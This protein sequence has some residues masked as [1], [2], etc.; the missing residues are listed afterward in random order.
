MRLAIISGGSKG[1]GASLCNQYLAAGFTVVEFSRS[2]P[3]DYSI[4]V[5]LADPVTTQQT[6]AT[7]LRALAGQKWDEI[8]VI[9]NAGVLDPIGPT[10]VKDP[11]AVLANINTNFA[12]AIVFISEVVGAFQGHAARKIIASVSSGAALKGYAGWSLYCA[13]KAGV[14]NFIRSVALEQIAQSQP[15]F[16]INIDPGVMDTGMQALI[17]SS[18][19][20]DFPDVARFV[21]RKQA[22]ELRSADAVARA[23]RQIIDQPALENGGRYPAVV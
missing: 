7:T 13:A 22:G 3:H 20:A 1:L 9:N 10:S 19:V 16:A 14:E 23:I 4:Q 6:V 15:F 12:S 21:Q 5:D 17:R 8:V 2:A 11:Q 18:T